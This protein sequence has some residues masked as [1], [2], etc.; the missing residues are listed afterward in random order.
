VFER[1]RKP[2][3]LTTVR[4]TYFGEDHTIRFTAPYLRDSR[5]KQPGNGETSAKQARARGRKEIGGSALDRPKEE[6]RG[7]LPETCKQP[8]SEQGV[9]FRL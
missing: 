7:D 1:R 5:K 3:S 4:E 6:G 2:R 8:L 9:A